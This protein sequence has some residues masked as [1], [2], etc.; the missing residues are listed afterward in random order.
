MR[1]PSPRRLIRR[2]ARERVFVDERPDLALGFRQPLQGRDVDLDVEVAGIGDDGAA[3]HG[4][5]M[6]FADD[7]LVPGNGHE[8][9]PDPGGLG[10]GDDGEA[11]H[12]GLQGADGVYLAN[13]DVGPRA[14]GPHG[15]ALAAPAVAGD[16]EIRPGQKDIGGPENAV[17]GALAGPVAVIEEVLCVGVVDGDDRVVQDPSPGPCCGGG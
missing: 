1:R 8:D 9:V 13:E 2:A 12:P 17:Q 5:K 4:Q 10:H 14:F 15:Q 3:L 16:D 6:F 7:A 11:V